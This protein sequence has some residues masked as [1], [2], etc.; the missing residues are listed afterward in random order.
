MMQDT[1]I[2]VNNLSRVNSWIRNIPR[3]MFKDV[4]KEFQKSAL[5]MSNQV[6]D[7]TKNK[8]KV[9][10]GALRRSIG[11][12]VTGTSIMDLQASIYSAAYVGSQELKYAKIHEYG[13]TINAIDKYVRVPGGPYLNIPTSDNKTAAGVTR[14]QAREVFNQGGYIAK[15]RSG[16]W[17]VF[18][19]GKMMFVLKKSV[20]IPERLGMRQSVDD[21]IPTLLGNLA[22][23]I[24]RN[25]D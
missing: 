9:R 20:T 16:K 23:I 8:L 4:K 25:I 12:E 21:E 17:G 18:L 14:L 19:D 1:D 5:A 22:N 7:N 10:T 13:G 24:G 2:T 3:A 15:T 6:K 11:Q